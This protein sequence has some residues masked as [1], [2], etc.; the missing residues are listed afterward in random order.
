MKKITESDSLYDGLE[1]MSVKKLLA[2]I[3]AEDKTV[4][5]SVEKTIPQIENLVNI[6]VD[7]VSSGG[8]LFY[9]G[10][11]TSGRL[12][13][14]DA[15]ECPPTFGV[16]DSMVIGLIAGG[17]SAIRKAVE[18]AEDNF[19]LG[20]L[21]LLEY[22]VNSN[23]IV[24]GVLNGEFTVKKIQKTKTKLFMVAANKDYKKIEIT[25]EM[26]FS[27]WGV[28]TFVIHKTR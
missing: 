3:N 24:I 8:R 6:A 26:D 16:S 20:W 12:A 21:D 23:D 19:D 4:A 22:N 1:K 2:S 28:V 7:K 27:V 17:D 5:H 10:A 13:I 11:G 18:F 14:V 15:S 9:V 25:E